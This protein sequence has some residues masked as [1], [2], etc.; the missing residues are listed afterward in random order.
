MVLITKM[1]FTVEK[2]LVFLQHKPFLGA[3][4]VQLPFYYLL[5]EK[6][7]EAHIT[8]VGTPGSG[9]F[10]NRYGM[11]DSLHIV[12]DSKTSLNELVKML[13]N[14][15]FT[16]G[17]QHR[18]HSFRFL[19]TAIRLCRNLTG[20]KNEYL[21]IFQKESYLFDKKRYIAHN[22]LSLIDHRLEDYLAFRRF[23]RGG[24]VCIIPA[25]S[26]SIKKYPLSQYLK[27]ADE[28]SRK[29]EVRFILGPDM[30]EEADILKNSRYPLDIN[31]TL[32]VLEKT[33]ST[34]RLVITNDCGPGHFAHIHDTPRISLFAI[35]KYTHEWFYPSENSVLLLPDE[36]GDISRIPENI[37]LDNAQKFI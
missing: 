15:K 5:R 30:Q 37:V 31:L 12:D 13:H 4:I 8:A 27:I 35:R 29:R 33:V 34:A 28:I 3:Q 9:E 26:N 10:L 11:I 19:V 18:R 17:F 22:Y 36:D 7:P 32:P 6:Y 24:H 20:F 25:G 16:L 2:I 23:D 21:N 1:G 14:E